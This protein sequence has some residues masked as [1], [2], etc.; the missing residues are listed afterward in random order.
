HFVKATKAANAKLTT[1]RVPP[2]LR[3][4]AVKWLV[5]ELADIF[6]ERTGQDPRDNIQSNYTKSKYKGAFFH[7]A[8]EILK[9]VGHRRDNASQGRMIVKALLRPKVLRPV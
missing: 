6:Q 8:D 3:L 9:R 7:L 4:E 2:N 1:Q 5:R